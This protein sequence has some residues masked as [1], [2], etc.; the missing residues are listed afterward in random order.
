MLLTTAQS[1]LDPVGPYAERLAALWWVMLAVTSVVFIVVMVWLA[2]A[3]RRGTRR[4]IP[5][6]THETTR[7]V[8]RVITIAMSISIATLL[9]LLVYSVSTGR[10][11]SPL[12]ARPALRIQITGHQWWWSVRY[13]DPIAENSFE[14]ANEIH[15]PVGKPVML[16]LLSADVIHSI[17]VPNVHGKR[18]LIPGKENT[19]VIQV[20]K[21][22]VYR[23]QCAEF[24]GWQHAKMGF[25]VVADSHDKFERW[26]EEQRKSAR[27]PKNQKE[28]RGQ[29]VFMST[30]CVM[31]HA[32]GGTPAGSHVGPDLTHFGS[33]GTIGAGTL[34]NT[35]GH[36]GGWIMNAQS[37]K[38]GTVMPPNNLSSDDLQALLTYLGSLK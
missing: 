31:C 7:K 38:P 28:L 2:I 22:G 24:C 13:E 19:F 1:A 34:P 6:T 17:W 29:E 20:D 36:L 12:N 25:L 8:T 23:G 9:V 30:T 35:P 14:T 27:Q 37:I 16:K 26:Q 3:I 21:P 11:V 5:D 4:D 10:A 18:D 15:I 33:R 32:I